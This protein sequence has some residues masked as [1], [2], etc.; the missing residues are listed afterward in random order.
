MSI[1]G[2]G[3][4]KSS[5]AIARHKEYCK[6]AACASLHHVVSDSVTIKIAHNHTGSGNAD[7][8][9]SLRAFYR[10]G[11]V[12]MIQEDEAFALFIGLRGQQINL[13]ILV[14]ISRDYIWRGRS[15]VDG[16]LERLSNGK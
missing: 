7:I 12:A 1:S 15:M 13:A 3:L 16:P 4:I 11:T 10:E 8:R 5:G 14:Y 9:N 6:A 2:I